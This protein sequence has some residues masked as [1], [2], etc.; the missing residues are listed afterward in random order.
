MNEK[1]EQTKTILVWFIFAYGTELK[2]PQN[3]KIAFLDCF[4][5]GVNLLNNNLKMLLQLVYVEHMPTTPILRRKVTFFFT[6][7]WWDSFISTS[8]YIKKKKNSISTLLVA[9]HFPFYFPPLLRSPTYTTFW[10]K[11]ILC[12][13]HC[14]TSHG[15][16]TRVR[17]V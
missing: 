9:F 8:L 2:T 12:P 1:R 4:M 10:C 16:V 13:Q 5:S 15:N 14:V 6:I 11:M 7:K 3:G 17:I